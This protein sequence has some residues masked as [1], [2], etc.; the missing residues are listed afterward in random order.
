MRGHGATQCRRGSGQRHDAYGHAVRRQR[1][2]QRSETHARLNHRD[3]ALEVDLQDPVHLRHVENNA[4][5]M[6]VHA[7][8]IHAA[9]TARV[10]RGRLMACAPDHSLHVLDRARLDGEIG[11]PGFHHRAVAAVRQEVHL[12]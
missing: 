6:R 8:G 4:A 10:E 5:G 3:A 1:L 11:A 12:I 7:A 2:E 9:A